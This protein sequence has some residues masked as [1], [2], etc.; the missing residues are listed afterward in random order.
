[1]PTQT[2]QPTQA[3]QAPKGAARTDLEFQS[4]DFSREVEIAAPIN[5]AFQAVLAQVGPE[6]QMP[7]GKPFPMKLE[8]WPGG[9]WWRDLGDNAGHFWGHVQVIKPPT[10]LE[11]SGPMFMSYPAINHVQYRLSADE[12]VGGT[13]L[14]FR[15]RAYGQLEKDFVEGVDHGW[16]FY[17]QRIAEIAQRLESERRAK[18]K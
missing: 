7:G 15:H 16:N 14:N 10:L 12:G 4:L 11:L 3:T 18:G 13:R 8:L 9:R 17:L 2:T 6:G 1:M 5:I